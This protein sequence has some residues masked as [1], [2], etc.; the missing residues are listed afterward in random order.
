[1]FRL[2]MRAAF[3][4]GHVTAA[5]T[6]VRA[7]TQQDISK[8]SE[9]IP[10]SSRMGKNL[11]SSATRLTADSKSRELEANYGQDLSW[12]PNYSVKVLGCHQVNDWNYDADGDE[13][14]RIMTKK[15]LR[16]R[17]CP[18][19]SCGSSSAMGCGGFGGGSYGDY[20]VG[21]DVFLQNYLEYL[22]EENSNQCTL[23]A[24]SQCGCYDDGNKD[25]GFNQE[26]CEFQCFY[27]YDKSSCYYDYTTDDDGYP[28]NFNIAD[29]MQCGEWLPPGYQGRRRLDAEEGEDDGDDFYQKV[30]G[31]ALKPYYIGPYCSSKGNSVFLGLFL[32]DT[33]SEFADGQGGTE[34]Y[35]T[36]TSG[37][38]MPFSIQSKLISGN[39]VSCGNQYGAQDDA[40]ED[41]DE[42]NQNNNQKDAPMV[43]TAAYK[44]AGKCERN[45]DI[46]NPN[47][48]ACN[49]ID[50]IALVEQGA[51]KKKSAFGG[52]SLIFL[53]HPHTSLIFLGTLFGVSAI[54]A[55]TLRKKLSQQ[56]FDENQ[57]AQ[58]AF[59]AAQMEAH[60]TDLKVKDAFLAM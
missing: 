24:Q 27:K 48:A 30:D 51:S 11:L 58:I 49:F 21:M 55:L 56:D 31:V 29:Y 17:L 32:D 41:E 4:I 54:Y 12:L 52:F 59:N 22:Q 10:V 18:E 5:M 40:V 26:Q 50:G 8:L 19:G 34:V 42:E 9:G 43:C 57:Q 6:E 14:V 16:F 20:I 2:N 39:C 37:S 36:L 44:G 35:S 7:I 53:N 47:V 60:Y 23:W 45:L 1:M 28:N 33:C 46:D 15:L 3:L 38:E 25:D 13:D